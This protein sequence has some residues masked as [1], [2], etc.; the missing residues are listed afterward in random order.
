MPEAPQGDPN[1]P[2]YLLELTKRWVSFGVENAARAD[3][4]DERY[5]VGVGIIEN[6]EARDRAAVHKSKR[7]F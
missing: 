7:W 6:C 1:S 2:A 5:R 3:K 4:A